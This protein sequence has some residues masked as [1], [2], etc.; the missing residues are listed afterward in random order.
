MSSQLT[1]YNLAGVINMLT[2]D[3]AICVFP[4]STL[5][6]HTFYLCR[7]N[8]VPTNDPISWIAKYSS[9]QFRIVVSGD[10]KADD[11]SVLSEQRYVGDNLCWVVNHE[12]EFIHFLS[13]HYELTPKTH[14]DMNALLAPRRKPIVT[15]SFKVARPNT[16]T[17]LG[18][19]SVVLTRITW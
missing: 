12:G 3:R 14:P 8:T 17:V 13:S 7:N 9:R 18:N 11:P 1:Y 5:I 15:C 6:E 4:R 2:H 16:V 10:M 19:A